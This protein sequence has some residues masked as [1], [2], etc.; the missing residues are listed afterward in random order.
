MAEHSGRSKRV[1]LD[2]PSPYLSLNPDY[3]HSSA[4]AVKL[5]E[6]WELSKCFEEKSL[7]FDSQPFKHCILNHFFTELE[8][9]DLLQNELSKLKLS[10]KSSD[11]LQCQQSKDLSHPKSPFLKSFVNCLLT[12]IIPFLSKSTQLDLNPEN[13]SLSFAKYS[14]GDHLLC[15]DDQ[16]EDRKLAFIFYLVPESWTLSDGGTLDLFSSG[17][18]VPLEIARSVLPQRNS[19]IFFEVSEISFHQVAEILTS[20]KARLSLTGW[21]HSKSKLPISLPPSPVPTPTP[22]VASDI[23]ILEPWISPNYLNLNCQHD[24]REIFSVQS[25]IKLGNFLREEKF[26][27]LADALASPSLEWEWNG[28][29]NNERYQTI[30]PGFESIILTRFISL[31]KSD[32]FAILLSHLTGLKLCEKVQDLESSGSDTESES[33]ES[34]NIGYGTCNTISKWIPG[35]YSLLNFNDFITSKTNRLESTIFFNFGGKRGRLDSGG[36]WSYAACEGAEGE[37]LRIENQDNSLC[38]VYLE[39]GTGKFVKYI[40]QSSSQSYVSFSNLHFQD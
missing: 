13:I 36:F 15:H 38:L 40:S 14:S 10:K 29:W 18:M 6:S 27:Q 21:F 26:S 8:S 7:K 12:D 20:K 2:T 23:S 4:L 17:S 35:A 16:L 11:L 28:I 34:T 24:I 19:L 33:E 9:V 32:S 3:L 5:Q 1:K 39:K 37:L 30:K 22:L 25:E 31:L